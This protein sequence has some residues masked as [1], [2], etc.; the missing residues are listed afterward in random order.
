MSGDAGRSAARRADATAG[1]PAADSPRARL[2]ALTEFATLVQCAITDGHWE[3]GAHGDGRMPKPALGPGSSGARDFDGVG[4]RF[5]FSRHHRG[6][7]GRDA[8]RRQSAR[9]ATVLTEAG[10]AVTVDEL[11]AMP[12]DATWVRASCSGFT[13]VAKLLENGNRLVTAESGDYLD[14][15]LDEAIAAMA[16][17]AA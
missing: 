4:Y 5:T 17:G 11:G 15:T 7:R 2:Q 3:T 1:V 6:E 9:V 8:V 16:D 12:G 14:A 10:C 13:V